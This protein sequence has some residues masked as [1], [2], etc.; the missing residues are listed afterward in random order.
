LTARGVA[1]TRSAVLAAIDAE[2][3]GTLAAR[4]A[5]LRDGRIMI[6]RGERQRLANR[7]GHAPGPTVS[8]T[9]P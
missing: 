8:F 7:V 5:E 2:W 1:P 6:E 3:L 9:V 4:L